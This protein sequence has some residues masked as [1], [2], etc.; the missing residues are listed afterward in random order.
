MRPAV[1]IDRVTHANV[2]KIADIWFD[3]DIDQAYNELLEEGMRQFP[4]VSFDT[5]S[6]GAVENL[7]P[8]NIHSVQSVSSE[9]PL[10]ITFHGD[11]GRNSKLFVTN[12]ASEMLSLTIDDLTDKLR[13][14]GRAKG[15]YERKAA[16]CLRR[17]NQSWVGWG[18]GDCIA[19]LQDRL[20]RY[21]QAEC[22]NYGPEQFSLIFQIDGP[23]YY[24]I[25]GTVRDTSLTELTQLD[26][27][28]FSGDENPQTD[29]KLNDLIHG[30][31]KLDEQSTHHV[32]S[33]KKERFGGSEIVE[34]IDT[35]TT[36]TADKEGK[37]SIVITDEWPKQ[38]NTDALPP[39]PG[40]P[41]RLP[42]HFDQIA[43]VNSADSIIY[44]VREIS[45]T[46]ENV[47]NVSAFGEWRGDRAESQ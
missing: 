8:I 32:E 15:V 21:K 39:I 9:V 29:S 46:V 42:V 40:V 31:F 33:H 38:I 17:T 7:I 3:G 23:Q 37:F 45:I 27:Q 30:Q 12:F 11:L 6:D 44:N 5:I 2:E 4:P 41:E 36:T 13:T 14:I 26:I 43:N 10:P 25:R 20:E 34:T 47:V 19:A 28:L 24:C 16:F 18:F 35:A 1:D 22:S